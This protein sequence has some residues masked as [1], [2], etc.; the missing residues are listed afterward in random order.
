MQRFFRYELSRRDTREVVRHLVWQCE[1][2]LAVAIEAG[3]EEGYV[4]EDGDFQNA[5]VSAWAERPGDLLGLLGSVDEAEIEL[6]RER[7]RGIGLWHTLEKQPQSHRLEMIR[8]DRRMQTWGLY[9]RLLETCRELG[10]QA[11]GRA[12]E[13]AQ[14]ALAVVE[15]LDPA[16]HGAARLAD[17]R[18]CALA[19]LGNAKRLASDFEGGGERLPERPRG[20]GAGDGRSAARGPPARAPGELAQDLGA[21]E[22]A[23][24][25]L[26]LAAAIYRE[27]HDPHLEGRTLLKQAD[28]VGYVQPEKAIELAQQ[29]LALVDALREPRLEW[30]AR[31]TL[32]LALNDAGR[33]RE[34]LAMLE[35]SRPLYAQFKDPWTRIRLRWLEGKIARS[36]GDLAEAEETFRRLWYDLQEP[37][38]LHELTLLS[39][40]LAEVCVARG[41]HEEALELVEEL[42][43]V[44]EEWGMHAEGRAM[45]LLMQRA[46]H[47]RR[48]GAALFR[49][50]AEYVSRA[51]FRPLEG[52]EA[53]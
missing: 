30:C 33:P 34:A 17:F 3:A 45:W 44:L 16:E 41:K 27:L 32:A 50:M 35:A 31:H 1:T 25:L 52:R 15:T 49:G 2:C 46:V 7:L 20:A 51:W 8:R 18:A 43:P 29:G 14:L 23:L 12:V 9:D 22:R 4:Y 36:L 47:E 37:A 38:Y 24:A 10:F 40:D 48:A 28:A 19:A 21:F 13:V 6:A 26:D 53:R 5:L 11:P 42:G 39:I